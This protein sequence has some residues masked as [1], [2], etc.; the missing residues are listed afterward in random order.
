MK[1]V[2]ESGTLTPE[3]RITGNL[4][5]TLSERVSGDTQVD[6]TSVF[7]VGVMLGAA[8]ERD[9]PKDSFEEEVWRDG[10]F[11]LRE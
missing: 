3:S 4:R 6:M 7:L 8:F 1:E 9:V 5:L 10:G 11:Q 2:I